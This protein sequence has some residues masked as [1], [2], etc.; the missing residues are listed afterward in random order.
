MQRLVL[1]DGLIDKLFDLIIVVC[2]LLILAAVGSSHFRKWGVGGECNHSPRFV[3]SNR[4]GFA[5]CSLALD[6]KGLA[7]Q[8]ASCSIL[9]MGWRG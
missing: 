8:S 6:K 3:E 1:F 5:P 9:E 2:I 4:L 7:P